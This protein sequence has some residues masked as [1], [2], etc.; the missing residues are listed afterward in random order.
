MY[1]GEVGSGLSKM[2]ESLSGVQV[3]CWNSGDDSVSHMSIPN[4]NV[5]RSWKFH[6]A[7]RPSW[8][9]G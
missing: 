9:G 7:P 6:V 4:Q 3:V 8:V 5:G 2:F 1:L